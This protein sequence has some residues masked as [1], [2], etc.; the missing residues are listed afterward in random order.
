M[1]QIQKVIE[2]AEFPYW[3]CLGDDPW[4]SELNDPHQ[5]F[6]LVANREVRVARSFAQGVHIIDMEYWPRWFEALGTVAIPLMV[7]GVVRERKISLQIRDIDIS[8]I[9]IVR[10]KGYV[11]L[12]TTNFE[13]AREM[14]RYEIM[15]R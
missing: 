14:V 2:S 12:R 4:C 15:K 6:I 11:I 1:S 3:M 7:T 13:L 9:F 8:P 10:L 5:E